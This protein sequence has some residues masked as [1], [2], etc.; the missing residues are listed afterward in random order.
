MFKQLADWL[1]DRTGYRDLMQG[2]T[3]RADPR[4]RA[5]AVRLR[6]GARRSSSWSRSSPG[7]CLMTSYSPS[8]S[9]AWGSVFYISHEMWLGWFIRGVHHFAAQA[10]VVLL[11]L[12]LLQVFWAGAYR[13]PRESTGGSGW[14][15]CS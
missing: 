4:R 10:M 9:T 15:S 3:R 13:R 12:H 1:D 7:S 8:S 14:R 6:L 2:G 11:V 5:L